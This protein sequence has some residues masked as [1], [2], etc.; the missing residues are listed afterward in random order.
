M[1]NKN[2]FSM[3][4]SLGCNFDPKLIEV[5][6]K[7]DKGKS[8]KSVF[9][10]M[11]SDLLG[12]GRASMVLPDISIRELKEYIELCHSKG[13][14]FNYLLNPMCMENKEF[15]PRYHKKII[16]YIDNL[17]SIGI[18]AVT[19]NSPYLCE[20]IKKRYPNI[21]VSIGLYA[22]IFDLHHI[23]YWHNLGADELTLFHKIN[24]NFELLEKMLNYTKNSNMSLRLIANNVCLHSCPYAVMHGTSQA[25]ASQ[26]KHFS[27]HVN[28]DYCLLKCTTEKIKNPTQLIASEWIRPEDIKH[29]ENLCEKTG[30]YNFSIKLL[31][32]TKST[33]FLTKVIKAYTQKVYNGNLLDIL[34]WPRLSE[35]VKV[36]KKPFIFKAITGRYN[37][38]EVKKFFDAFNLPDFYLDN[39]KLDGFL[40]KFT[41]KFVC[42]EFTCEGSEISKPSGITKCSYCKT[43]AEK[44]ISFNDEERKKWLLKTDSVNSGLVESKIFE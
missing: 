16:S 41:T 17:V 30:N 42:D 27:K 28:L 24:R 33:D 7:I 15:S 8:I 36:H 12:G 18:D 29:Y 9:G 19:V 6:S 32:R 44:A 4:Y 1:T 20:L 2:N 22:Y 13:L 43:W 21:K 34:V 35:T 5:I 3:P 31:D 11:R 40:E 37:I 39:R 23:E 26:N 10:K 25:H 38:D 14:K